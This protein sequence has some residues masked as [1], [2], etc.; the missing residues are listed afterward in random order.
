MECALEE[1]V[2]GEALAHVVLAC[3]GKVSWVHLGQAR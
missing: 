2:G 1:D 3:A